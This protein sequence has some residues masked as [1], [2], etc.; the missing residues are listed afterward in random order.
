MSMDYQSLEGRAG[1][2]EG[3]DVPFLRE[4]LFSPQ[5]RPFMA[6][7]TAELFEA[8]DPVEARGFLRQIGARMATEIPLRKHGNLEELEAGINAA[9][10]VMAWGYARLGLVG[11]EIEVTHH[12]YPDL[13]PAH[14]SRASWRAGFAAILE[15]LYTAWLQLQGG[16]HDMSAKAA[17]E[18]VEAAA[19][20]LRF[21]L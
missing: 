18:S 21:G 8:F 12:A 5:W 6:S 3:G 17:P 2:A 16:R 15:G 19:V 13:N 1:A 7:L 11:A 9:L 14:A 20:T 4:Q 10:T